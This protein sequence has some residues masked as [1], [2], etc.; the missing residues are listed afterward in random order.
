MCATV[1]QGN[2]GAE[3]LGRSEPHFVWLRAKNGGEKAYR[4]R[5]V[6]VNNQSTLA[7]D[8]DVESS[9]IKILRFGRPQKT[10]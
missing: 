4:F 2:D 6:V 9:Q 8:V 5:L 10:Q 1:G 7:G 3:H